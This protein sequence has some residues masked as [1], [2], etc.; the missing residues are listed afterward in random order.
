MKKEGASSRIDQKFSKLSEEMREC[1]KS[2]VA[3]SPDKRMEAKDILRFS[4]FD[5]IRSVE[6]EQEAEAPIEMPFERLNCY[7]Y[8]E[9]V[10]HVPIES[11]SVAI[12]EEV[13]KIRNIPGPLRD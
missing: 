13:F 1:L 10:D 4:C 6:Q 2:M 8:E 5:D 12:E 9:F 3:F 7:D 11:F